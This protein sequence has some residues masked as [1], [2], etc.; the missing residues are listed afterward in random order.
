MALKFDVDVATTFFSGLF[1]GTTECIELRSFRPSPYHRAWHHLQDVVEGARRAYTAGKDVRFGV[2]TKVQGGGK[3]EHTREYPFFCLDID[4]DPDEAMSRVYNKTRMPD[5]TAVVHS[6]RGAHIYWQFDTPTRYDAEVAGLPFA[7]FWRVVMAKLVKLTEADPQAA[8][9]TTLLR[10]PGTYNLKRDAPVLLDVYRPDATFDP[11]Y[12]ALQLDLPA[13]SLHRYRSEQRPVPTHCVPRSGSA[14]R[15]DHAPLTAP[16]D[17][18]AQVL[19]TLRFRWHWKLPGIAVLD[20][21]PMCLDSLGNT[22]YGKSWI[23]REGRIRCYRDKCSAGA[24][25]AP[26]GLAL[27]DWL[28]VLQHHGWIKETT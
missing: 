12:L 26:G 19:Y 22:E 27:Q 5:P 17:W 10:I 4:C 8:L 7:L 15:A 23:D 9:C 16:P 14:A 13:E 21:C 20:Q 18:L 6:G 24:M 11:E 2:T 3:T 25:F 1:A 28:P